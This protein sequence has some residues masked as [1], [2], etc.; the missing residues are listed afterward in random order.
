VERTRTTANPWGRGDRALRRHV[1]AL[2]SPPE[3]DCADIVVTLSRIETVTGQMM[4][5]DSG[6]RRSR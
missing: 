2:K 4:V 6:R 3:N 5:I 1:A